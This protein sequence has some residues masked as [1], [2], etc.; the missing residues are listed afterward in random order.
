MSIVVWTVEGWGVD[1]GLVSFTHDASRYC[2]TT[3]HSIPEMGQGGG[4]VGERGWSETNQ[5]PLVFLFAW[6]VLFTGD[7]H[8]MRTYA[9]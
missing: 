9:I 3:K 1:E 6:D 7:R 4:G 5:C 2:S 8:P